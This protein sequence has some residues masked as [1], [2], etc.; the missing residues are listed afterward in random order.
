MVSANPA[1]NNPLLGMMLLIL[2]NHAQIQAGF[3]HDLAMAFW[4]PCYRYK[5]WY[6]K[7][8][9]FGAWRWFCE[10]VTFEQKKLTHESNCLTQSTQLCY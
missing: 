8:T 1:E 4:L 3:D 10:V 6:R 7:G 9:F 2:G 5:V